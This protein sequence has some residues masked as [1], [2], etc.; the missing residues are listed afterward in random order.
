MKA[1]AVSK[2]NSSSYRSLQTGPVMCLLVGKQ[3]CF[4]W[5]NA[6]W[7]DFDDGY[8][9]RIPC[10]RKRSTNMSNSIS[11]SSSNN[12]NNN[13][14]SSDN[15]KSWCVPPSN[16]CKCY[17]KLNQWFDIDLAQQ[18]YVTSVIII[19]F[20]FVYLCICTFLNLITLLHWVPINLE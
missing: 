16:R 3:H 13:S 20:Y 8:Q 1:T 2:S 15:S 11:N 18:S 17:M 7:S 14:N 5:T 6:D 9:I 12:S 19:F 10:S 4:T